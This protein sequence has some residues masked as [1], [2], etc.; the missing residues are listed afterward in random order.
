MGFDLPKAQYPQLAQ[1]ANFFDT[2]LDRV[3][4][5]PGVQGA[6]LV[7]P[8]VP[9][10]GYG[11]DSSFTIAEHPPLPLGKGQFAIYRMVDPE[12]FS[13]IGI[14]LRR[15]RTFGDNQ[16]PGHATEAIVSE[17]FVRQYFPGEDPIGSHVKRHGSSQLYEVVGIVGD[18][19]FDVGE[20]SRPMMYFALDADDDMNGAT[21]VIRSGGDVTR[22]AIPVQ[23]IVQQ[24][25][26][27]L[28]V[29][30]ILTMDQVI[31][32]NTADANFDA[33]LL[34]VFAASSL[35][36][37]AVGL[38][39]VLSY[40]VAQRTGEIGIRMAL[41]ARREQVARLMLGD[42]LRPALYGLVLGLIAS[43][44]VTRLI[45][46]MLYQTKALDLPVLI[47]V[48][49][50]LLV[51]AAVACLLPA[52]RAARVDPMKALRTE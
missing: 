18:T 7:F 26:R 44:A 6:G 43:A 17:S 24:L 3:R 1:R 41:G 50:I 28:P 23:Q 20:P 48:S 25:D 4:N 38:F 9:G 27:N 2:L 36:L 15:G 13:A 33:T 40:V 47:A 49:L 37:A 8:L 11:G 10:D 16:R 21:L 12:Y 42:G 51:V 5:L 34:L 31:G 14:P 32:R 45:E 22:Y 29:S 46:S 19:R 52:W 35:L 30:D 39:G